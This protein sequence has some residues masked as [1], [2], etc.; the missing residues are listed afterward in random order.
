MSDQEQDANER[1]QPL[2]KPSLAKAHTQTWLVCDQASYTTF[3]FPSWELLVY[4]P[5]DLCKKHGL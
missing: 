3:A 4:S 2:T 1:P 5:H